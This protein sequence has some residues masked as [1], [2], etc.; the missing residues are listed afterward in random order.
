MDQPSTVT[1]RQLV[2]GAGAVGTAAATLALSGCGGGSSGGTG[3]GVGAGSSPSGAAAG[4]AGAAGGAG[5]NGGASA[6]LANLADVPVGGAVAVKTA[7]GPVIVAQPKAGEAVAFSAVCTHQGCTVAPAGGHL[8]CPCHGS[9]FNALTGAVV[10]GPAP[11]PL[12]KVNVRVENGKV[13]SA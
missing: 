8:D 11:S 12:A 9:R 2:V 6:P 1:R 5:S 4:S 13:I 10:K 3:V 7:G